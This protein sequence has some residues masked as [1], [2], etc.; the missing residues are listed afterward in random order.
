MIVNKLRRWALIK[1]LAPSLVLAV[2]AFEPFLVYGSAQVLGQYLGYQQMR[3]SWG[4]SWIGLNAGGPLL[5]IPHQV[6]IYI[7]YQLL[8]SVLADELYKGAIGWVAGLGVYFLLSTLFP[9]PVR[10]RR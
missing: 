9:P 6:V 3:F 2:L 10:S 7:L 8:P 4:Y 5:F 1:R